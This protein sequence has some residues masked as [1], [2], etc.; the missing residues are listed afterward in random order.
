[1]IMKIQR[2]TPSSCG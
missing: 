1:M 2:Q